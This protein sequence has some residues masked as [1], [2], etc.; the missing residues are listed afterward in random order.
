M[1][2]N[3]IPKPY[4]LIDH[5]AD[6]AIE[7]IGSSFTELMENAGFALFDIICNPEEI[8]QKKEFQI[9]LK[10]ESPNELL[11]TWLEALLEQFN[12]NSTVYSKFSVNDENKNMFT[13][14]AWGETIDLS[15]HTYHTEIKAITY[16]QF[17]VKQ[18]KDGWI[19]KIIFDV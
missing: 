6:L 16:H 4:T 7:V 13:C 10:Q 1:V 5:T 14:H 17:E 11:R 2:N 9:Q 19:A 12:I 18:N 15:K 3:M 8:A